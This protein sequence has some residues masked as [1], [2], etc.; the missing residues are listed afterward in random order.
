MVGKEISSTKKI[1]KAFKIIF[2]FCAFYFFLMGSTLIFLP[3]FLIKGFSNTEVNPIII[4]M[5]RG[6]GGSIIPYSLLYIMIVLKPFNRQWALGFILLANVIAI[7]LDL[8]S[9]LL[10]EYKLSYAMIDLP[11]EFTSIIGIIIIR[12]KTKIIKKLAA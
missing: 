4:G 10:G 3:G 8:G 5:L 11:V 7:I 2:Y 12:I 9:L 6:A 1:P